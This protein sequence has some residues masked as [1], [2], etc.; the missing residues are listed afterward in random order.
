MVRK[1]LF[2]AN[3]LNV[4]NFFFWVFS[5]MVKVSLN[6]KVYQYKCLN[7]IS[8]VGNYFKCNECVVVKYKCSKI[9]IPPT[10]WLKIPQFASIFQMLI[11]QK[12]V[13]ILYIK[14]SKISNNTKIVI[15]LE[16][17]F[18]INIGI[19]KIIHVKI[20]FSENHIKKYE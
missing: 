11:N 19:S 17:M 16:N 20:D 8:Q 18:N 12:R 2:S 10:Y 6:L 13:H 5:F 15:I 4:T 3:N 14:L 7:K 9:E 1:N